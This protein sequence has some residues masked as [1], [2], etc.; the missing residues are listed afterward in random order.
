MPSLCAVFHAKHAMRKTRIPN[1]QNWIW[2]GCTTKRACVGESTPTVGM[3][4]SSAPPIREPLGADA[5]ID[6]RQASLGI[7]KTRRKTSSASVPTSPPLACGDTGTGTPLL[8][9]CALPH[10]LS[11]AC[12]SCPLCLCAWVYSRVSL[13]VCVCVC[14]FV[15]VHCF[16]R[17]GAHMCVCNTVPICIHQQGVSVC[18]CA[19]SLSGLA[20]SRVWAILSS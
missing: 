1:H 14:V 19:S 4:T 17:C 16:P 18:L 9:F 2:S 10:P 6:W 13:P 3:M 12:S 8:F 5:A 11:G 20:C 15:F 7:G